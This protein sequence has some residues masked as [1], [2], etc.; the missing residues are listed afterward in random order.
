MGSDTV[1]TIAPSC[2]QR[3]LAAGGCACFR[4]PWISL[5]TSPAL[6]ISHLS[7][8]HRGRTILDSLSFTVPPGSLTALAGHPG[9]GKTAVM[10]LLA[11]FDK[12]QAG[13]VS[14]D[15]APLGRMPAY[16]RGFGVV[17]QP[18]RLFPH[19]SLAENVALPLRLRGVKRASRLAMARETLDLVQI[20]APADTR[21][22][23]SSH[24]DRQRALLAR[25]AVFGPKVMLLDE[26]FL[27][28]GEPPRLSLVA[29]LG[30]IHELLGAT[31]VLATRNL[32]DALPI[33]DHIV[34]LRAGMLEQA[35]APEPLFNRP[36]SDY[37]ASLC[38]ET[39]RLAGT[40]TGQEDDIATIQL[41]CGPV[42]EARNVVGLTEGAN[43]MFVLRPEHIAL[44]PVR[45]AE[46]GDGALDATLIESQFWGDSYRLRLLIGSG[47]EL[48]VR[49]PAIAGLRG[50]VAGRHCAVAWQS[51]HAM[52]FASS[53][54]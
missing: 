44:A 47:A 13:S 20:E 9:S 43:C 22:R 48:V 39:N 6:D 25:A 18:D 26:P 21:A 28:T 32:R 10:R 51:H 49:R 45:A 30:R 14:L 19:L 37:V 24:D 35:E 40:V 1:A 12:A 50:L 8:R 38:G 23:E 46:M 2:E 17:Q 29:A 5:V 31:I 15:G 36:A 3:T 34:V 27:T 41:A 11:G 52:V 7:L 42:V 53:V 16:K 33:C 4:T 54:S